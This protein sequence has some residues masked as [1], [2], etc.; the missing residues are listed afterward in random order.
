MPTESSMRQCWTTI[1]Q[2]SAV[3]TQTVHIPCTAF[4]IRS[5]FNTSSRSCYVN[6]SDDSPTNTINHF[7]ALWTCS[8]V[9]EEC[10]SFDYLM[11]HSILL[12]F[13]L[14]LHFLCWAHLHVS[15]SPNEYFWLAKLPLRQYFQGSRTCST[16][17]LRPFSEGI[18]TCSTL[19]LRQ[20][21]EEIRTCS[22]LFEAILWGNR[23]LQYTLFEAIL[24]GS[25]N[26][27]YTLFEAILW[28]SANLQY[29]LFEAILWGSPNLQYTLFEAILWGSPN[30]QY[31][32]FEA[33]LWGNQNLQYTLF[34]AI[35]WGNSLRQFSEGIRTCSAHSLR[36]FWGKVNLQYT[37]FNSLRKS[38]PAV[39]RERVMQYWLFSTPTS[40]Y[41]FWSKL[42]ME[43]QVCNSLNI[44]AVPTKACWMLRT[45]PIF[46]DLKEL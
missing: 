25:A 23:N 33:I 27:Q 46:T 3:Q 42:L 20:L 4:S 24:W 31:T 18:R 37:L 40:H 45:L 10:F 22:T 19:S 13:R 28:G 16:H 35:L 14:I 5:K 32:L 39:G 41:I 21:S 17:S 34:E 44:G 7:P 29:T 38:E 12:E 8:D 43:S 30:L 6:H 1:T 26:L 36:Q 11:S 15:T 9:L 2:N